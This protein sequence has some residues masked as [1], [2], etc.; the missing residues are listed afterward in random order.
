MNFRPNPDYQPQSM[1]ERVLRAMTG[2]VVIDP[3][4]R[5]HTLEGRLPEDVS[6]GFGLL[7]TIQAGSSFHTT[8]D[9]VPGNEWKTASVDT[10]IHGRAI[11]FKTIGKKEH[12]EHTE[13]KEL[14][15]GMSVAQA[16]EAVER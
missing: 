13:F 3:A 5:L 14:P 15:E 7:A 2:T 8:R 9:R 1:E 11:F 4:M 12:A 6:I 16:V 10:D